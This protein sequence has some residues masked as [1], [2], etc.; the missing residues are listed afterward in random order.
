M[1][2]NVYGQCSVSVAFPHPWVQPNVTRKYSERNCVCP[3]H[4]Q[5][6]FLYSITTVLI[7]FTLI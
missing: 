6:F 7:A 1:I 4:V 2:G 3:E 5:T